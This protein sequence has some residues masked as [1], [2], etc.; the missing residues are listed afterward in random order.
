M[1]KIIIVFSTSL[2]IF[3]IFSFIVVYFSNK[4]LFETI[5]LLNQTHHLVVPNIHVLPSLGKILP[6]FCASLFITFTAGIVLSLII[7][8]VA[9]ILVRSLV[10]ESSLSTLFF[11]VCLAGFI[12][13][14]LIFFANTDASVFL[15][16]RDTFLL[17]SK[18]GTILNDFYYRYTPYA[19]RAINSPLQQQMKICWIDSEISHGSD[20]NTLLLKSGWI[21]IPNPSAA[22]LIIE[23]DSENIVLLKQAGKTILSLPMDDFE[24]D[25][26]LYL[27][28]FSQKTDT[29]FLLR[30][31]CSAGLLVAT[32]FVCFMMLFSAMF[33]LYTRWIGHKPAIYLSGIS[34]VALALIALCYLNPPVV[35]TDI[36]TLLDA[37]N[38]R[39]RTE[40]L[41]ILYQKGDNIR[42]IPA[43]LNRPLSEKSIAERYWL[44]MVLSNPYPKNIPYIK[45]L[46]KDDALNVRCAAIKAL[47]RSGCSLESIKLFKEIVETSPHW[48]EQYYALNAFRSCQ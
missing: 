7:C 27:K 2:A 42:Q 32:P 37:K 17:S 11:L 16:A 39:V 4:N 34:M 45:E 29:R 18:P 21:N 9:M 44:A 14:G 43:Y 3:E 5:T 33:F 26:V 23:K 41:R 19:A 8:L 36:T 20:L 46:I 25:P 13:S 30:S 22:A 24:E 31:G 12:L 47:S 38:T 40:A 28:E 15:R 6:A 35:S 48:Y 10:F 1:K